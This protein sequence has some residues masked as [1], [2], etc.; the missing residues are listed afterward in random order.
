[1]LSRLFS[2]TY[3]MG[4]PFGTYRSA[5]VSALFG[6][7]QGSVHACMAR[8]FTLFTLQVLRPYFDV[9]RH[10]L[11]ADVEPCAGRRRQFVGAAADFCLSARRRR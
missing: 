2:V 7:P 10:K 1:M 11:Y 8:Y 4:S 5:W 9:L 3:F 6:V